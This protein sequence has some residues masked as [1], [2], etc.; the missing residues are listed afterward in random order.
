MP[1]SKV[2]KRPP[3][4]NLP[5]IKC[6][7]SNEI[8]LLPESKNLG[9]AIEEHAIEYKKKHILTQK[10]ADAIQD[11]LIGQA[12][13]MASEIEIRSSNVSKQPLSK[14]KERELFRRLKRDV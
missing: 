6:E 1:S 4:T 10:E 13:R 9:K 5:I 2:K 11:N 8:L 7:C 14:N 3:K 12:L